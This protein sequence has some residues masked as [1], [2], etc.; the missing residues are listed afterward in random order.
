MRLS[1]TAATERAIAFASDWCSRTGREELDPQ[2]LLV[3]LLSESEC[4]AAVMLQKHGIDMPAVCQKWLA[5]GLPSEVSPLD[6]GGT[7]SPDISP[8]GGTNQRIPFSPEVETRSNWPANGSIFFPAGPNWL[9]S[10][11]CWA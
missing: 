5:L 6:N 2:S 1:F 3:G 11:S 7:Q 4:R 8:H 10:T 9:P